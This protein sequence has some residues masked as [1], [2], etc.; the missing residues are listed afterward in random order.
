[1]ILCKSVKSISAY[2]AVRSDHVELAILT[3]VANTS[4]IAA[5]THATLR[6][7]F[8]RATITRT[9]NAFGEWTRICFFSR[10]AY[11]RYVK[12]KVRGGFTA[13]SVVFRNYWKFLNDVVMFTLNSLRWKLKNAILTNG[14][15]SNSY[16]LILTPFCTKR[17]S[18]ES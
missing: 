5:N 8:T 11:K 16:P 18:F 17:T 14:F 9:Q 6:V 1:V 2:I 3:V 12:F 15:S 10:E 7:T 13:V 4:S